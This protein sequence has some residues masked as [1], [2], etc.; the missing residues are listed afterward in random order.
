[1]LCV[2]PPLGTICF[3]PR[4]IKAAV[5]YSRPPCLQPLAGSA[6]ARKSLD[7]EGLDVTERHD[8]GGIGR[9]AKGLEE[10]EAVIFILDAVREINAVWQLTDLGLEYARRRCRSVRL[11]PS[12][13]TPEQSGLFLRARNRDSKIAITAQ[14]KRCLYKIAQ[15]LFDGLVI[16]GF[17]LKCAGC[18]DGPIAVGDELKRAIQ[19]AG[20][21]EV[22]DAG[23]GFIA[24]LIGHGSN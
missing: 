8:V 6:K 20:T 11:E 18:V 15:E 24:Q 23:G 3:T 13:V 14:A 12:P 9:Q 2:I 16:D 5:E 21:A 1:M 7:D 19:W 4:I 17:A 22:R 10:F